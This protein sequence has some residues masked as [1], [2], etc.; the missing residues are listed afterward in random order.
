MG[1][2]KICNVT[3]KLQKIKLAM[4]K[5]RARKISINAELFHAPFI[6]KRQYN[7]CTCKSRLLTLASN[8]HL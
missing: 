5:I 2:A 8:V 3:Y 6:Q 1:G 7:Y 4:M